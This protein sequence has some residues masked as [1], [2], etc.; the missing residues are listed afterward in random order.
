MGKIIKPGQIEIK[1]E[2]K[3][4]PQG[5]TFQMNLTTPEG[6]QIIVVIQILDY[7]WE[8]SEFLMNIGHL[9]ATD[10]AK[11]G[12]FGLPKGLIP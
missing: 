6:R 4:V 11:K 7:N 9:D 5:S 2:S 12:K 10:A 8:K 1:M 3:V